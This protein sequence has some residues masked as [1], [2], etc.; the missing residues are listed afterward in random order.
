[1]TRTTTT[2]EQGGL[3]RP[4]PELYELG[5]RV[6]FRSSTLATDPTIVAHVRGRIVGY[7]VRR[8]QVV[9]RVRIDR[10]T[11]AWVDEASI[12]HALTGGSA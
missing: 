6:V 10:W 12:L 5:Q 8:H 1:M 4:A 11:T 9:Y 3:G 2:Q 7:A